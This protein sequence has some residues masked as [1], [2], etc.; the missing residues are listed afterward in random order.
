[1]PRRHAI[2]L[3]VVALLVTA[4]AAA[5][6]LGQAAGVSVSANRLSVFRPSQLPPRCIAP[7]STLTA[8]A[9]TWVDLNAP[10]T[11]HG[12]ETTFRVTSR[13]TRDA[14]A[15]VR[16]TLPTTPTGCVLQSATLRLNSTTAT[17]GRTLSV[18]RAAAT[19]TEGTVKW[20]T[21]PGE[22]GTAVNAAAATGWVEWTVT[23]HVQAM[24]S[25]SNFGFR[26]RDATEGA[27]GN[28]TQTFGAR[29]GTL[30]PQLV[31]QW[32]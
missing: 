10:T 4:A 31:L 16:F 18:Y 27:T 14:R 25:G 30:D 15:L 29:E 23:T 32:G 6:P 26:V 8:V 13:S 1:M 22:T 3:G 24:Y 11:T 28:Q 5:G 9:D 20:N 17:V 12:A 2:A 7:A 21:Q 19:W